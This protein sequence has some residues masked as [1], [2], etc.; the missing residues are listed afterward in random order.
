MISQAKTGLSALA[1][2]HQLGASY[3][4]FLMIY[5]KLMHSMQQRDDHYLMGGLV[6]IDDAYLGGEL[7]AGKAGRGSENKVPFV[8]AVESN[9]KKRPI[10][11][12]MCRVSGFTPRAILRWAQ[13]HVVAGTTVIT[14]GLAFFAGVT[15]AGCKHIPKIAGG[16]K[17]KELLLF[18]WLNIILGN[19]KTGLGG[20]YHVF[21]S[22]KYSNCYLAEIAYRFN[23]RF[24]LKTMHQRLLMA[25]VGCSPWP[26][27][28]LR[29]AE[30]SC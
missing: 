1:L 4:T 30:S 24:N 22:S 23:R 2:N 5:R 18:Q 3:P 27:R 16:R 7:S 19:V 17:P 6:Q 25:A 10:R 11:M 29:S 15:E 26:E 13:N 21:L 14:D 9:D 8:A 20:A 28:H 12:R